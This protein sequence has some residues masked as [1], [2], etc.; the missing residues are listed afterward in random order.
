MLIYKLMMFFKNASAKVIYRVKYLFSAKFYV[1]EVNAKHDA[2]VRARNR[3]RLI[4]QLKNDEFRIGAACECSKEDNKI[5]RI[6]RNNGGENR[7]VK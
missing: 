6:D 3:A 4:N 5:V 1:D 2:E 7:Y